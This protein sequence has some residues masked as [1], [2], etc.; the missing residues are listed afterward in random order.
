MRFH[1]CRPDTVTYSALIGALEKGGQWLRAVKAFEQMQGQ[2]CRPDSSIYQSMV[3]MLWQSGVAWLQARALQLYAAAARSWQ[4]RF[5]VQ[6]A[7]PADAGLVEFIVPASTA[8]VA[9]LSTQRWLV[10]LRAALD[11]DGA[12]LLSGGGSGGACER[13]AVSLGRGRHTREQGCG[14]IRRAL[15]ALLEALG[16]PLRCVCG[17]VVTGWGRNAHACHIVY[18]WPACAGSI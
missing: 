4:F 15:F 11:R 6:Q 14:N 5:T 7:S 18:T 3:D 16:A 1:N 2:G 13:V 8:S 9:V 17:Q 10:E 12:L